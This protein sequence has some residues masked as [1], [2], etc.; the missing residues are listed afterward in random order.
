[1]G[2]TVE[3]LHMIVEE[4]EKNRFQ[5]WQ[6][7]HTLKEMIRAR[8]GHSIGPPH[9]DH[10]LL[11]IT[12]ILDTNALTLCVH[13]TYRKNLDAILKNGLSRMTRQHIHMAKGLFGEVKSGYRR[14]CNVMISIDVEKAMKEGGLKFYEAGNGVILSEGDENGCIPARYFKEVVDLTTSSASPPPSLSTAATTF[15]AQSPPVLLDVITTPFCASDAA[16]TLSDLMTKWKSMPMPCGADVITFYS[17]KI[18]TQNRYA[19]FSNFYRHRPIPFTIPSWC[20][21][22]KNEVVE[23][24]FSERS[25]MLCKASLFEDDIA[26]DAIKKAKAPEACKKLGRKVRGFNDKKWRK[27]LCSI[28]FIAVH[29]KFSQIPELRKILLET[30]NC[31]IAE[32]APND[33]IWGIGL[34]A[35]DLDALEPS[36]WNG[37]NVLGWALMATRQSIYS[38]SDS[39]EE[40]R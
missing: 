18:S 9:I 28:A 36:R 17:N 33:N 32:A 10:T 29:A 15:S 16:C 2:I 24:D 40:A 35:D 19:S 11:D 26:F 23:V 7:P 4:N 38:Y 21:C 3:D 27:H 8:Q 12:E 37:M 22:R 34:P 30:G 1:M 39:S 25:I 14:D 13:G 31:L 6:C 5:L 20:G